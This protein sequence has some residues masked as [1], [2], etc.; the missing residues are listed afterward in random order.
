MPQCDCCDD[1][2]NDDDDVSS[3]LIDIEFMLKVEKV[4]EIGDCTK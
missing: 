4:L 2:G 3:S 1:D